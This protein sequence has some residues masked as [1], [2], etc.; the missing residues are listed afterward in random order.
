[1]GKVDVG[2]YAD[3]SSRDEWETLEIALETLELL[4]E[5][6]ARA[7][8]T[9]NSDDIAQAL[10]EDSLYEFTEQLIREVSD[11]ISERLPDYQ[12]ADYS[13]TGDGWGIW[14]S[15][16]SLQD[17]IRYGEVATVD[18]GGNIVVKGEPI[19][20]LAVHVNDH[21]N[22]TLYRVKIELEEVWSVV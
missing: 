13:N 17:D 9:R 10:D 12:Y 2:L 20:T 7:Y 18:D 1:M 15:H 19:P 11:L 6:A 22:T 14:V 16:D 4:D 3:S 21:G 5:E 8:Y